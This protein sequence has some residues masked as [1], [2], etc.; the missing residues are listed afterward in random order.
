MFK[1]DQVSF[2][3]TISKEHSHIDIKIWEGYGYVSSDPRKP[4]MLHC[5]PLT[6][7]GGRWLWP[8]TP[9]RDIL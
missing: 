1:K 4:L 8:G 6:P 2:Y 5:P 3:K 7:P 9:G